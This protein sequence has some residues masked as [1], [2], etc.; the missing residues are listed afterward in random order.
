MLA[1]VDEASVGINNLLVYSPD[2]SFGSYHYWLCLEDTVLS[3]IVICYDLLFFCNKI[4]IIY[5]KSVPFLLI[6]IILQKM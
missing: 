6:I 3:A 4:L 2:L 5:F 1:F